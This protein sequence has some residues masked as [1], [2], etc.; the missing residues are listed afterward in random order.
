[1]SRCS[2]RWKFYDKARNK[3]RPYSVLAIR[4]IISLMSEISKMNA[5]TSAIVVFGTDLSNEE[6]LSPTK[7]QEV[8]EDGINK[9]LKNVNG[10]SIRDRDERSCSVIVDGS[11]EAIAAVQAFIQK[12]EV[13]IIDTDLDEPAVQAS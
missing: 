6:L 1:M 2:R 11:S 12:S 3:F 4:G 9:I 13:G 8:L 5:P 7:S 10:L